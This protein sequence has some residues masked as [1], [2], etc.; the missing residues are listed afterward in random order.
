MSDMIR[1]QMVKNLV[2]IYGAEPAGIVL[3]VT[4][5][6]GL[7]TTYQLPKEL[8]AGMRDIMQEALDHYLPPYPKG[9]KG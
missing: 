8:V 9:M 2:H 5:Q 4:T 6:D 7:V 1:T 3:R